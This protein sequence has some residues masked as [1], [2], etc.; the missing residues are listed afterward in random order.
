[1]GVGVFAVQ[2][3]RAHERGEGEKEFGAE[4]SDNIDISNLFFRF[5]LAVEIKCNQIKRK[6]TGRKSVSDF[7][8][9]ELGPSD[10]GQVSGA[11]N[12][13]MHMIRNNE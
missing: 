6:F 5:L 8:Y 4:K 2:F 10:K 11:E 3:P 7:F 13:Y 1:M 12:Q 9:C